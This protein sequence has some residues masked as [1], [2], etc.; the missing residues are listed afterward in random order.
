M[1]GPDLRNSLLISLLAGNWLRGDW[2]AADCI[3]S[4]AV[5]SLWH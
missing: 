1:E 5:S 3:V 2:F 4:R